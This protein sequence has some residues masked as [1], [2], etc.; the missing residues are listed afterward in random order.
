MPPGAGLRPSVGIFA[1]TFAG[2]TPD[3]V[4]G[5]AQRAG[6]GSVQYNMMCSGLPALPSII[7]PDV[8]PAIRAAVQHTGVTVAALSAT[9][10][11]IHPDAATRAAGHSSLTLLAAS[12]HA[13]GI[14]MLT[15]CTGSRNAGDQWAPHPDNGTADAWR[16]LL[17][18]MTAALEVAERFDLMLGVEPEPSNI[19][20]GADAARRLMAEL[21]SRR[22][23]VVLDAANLVEPALGESAAVRGELITRAVET[24]ADRIILVHAKDRAADGA[25]VAPGQGVVDFGGYLGALASAGVRAPVITHGLD[26]TDA[27]AAAVFL[28]RCIVDS[29]YG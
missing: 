3:S 27:P 14:P 16:D 2:S 26:A 12:A 7:T 5:Q 11:M 23:G 19:V 15:L 4:L 9:Y 6:Y 20:S 22:V 25:I 17:E 10:N 24:L 28:G 13:L 21:G 8:V 18:S 29:G 1:R